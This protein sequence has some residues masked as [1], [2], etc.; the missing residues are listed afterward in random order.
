MQ[1]IDQWRALILYG[2]NVATYKIALGKVLLDLAR[3]E[4]TT[5]NMPELA[6]AFLDTYIERLAQA[7][8]PQLNVSGRKTL[9]ERVVGGVSANVLQRNRAI[10]I[11][12]RDGFNDVVPRFHT[13]PVGQLGS[14]FYHQE[15]Y[16]LILDDSLIA[17]AKSSHCAELDS[18]LDS[19]W[20]LL[21]TAFEPNYSP[22]LLGTD[23]E[24]I[25]YASAFQRL[26]VTSARPVLWGYQNGRC[27][28]C[29]ELLETDNAHV[30]H[31]IPRAYIQHDEIWNLVLAHQ[32]CNLRKSDNIPPQEY[33]D[34]LYRRNEYY[35]ASNHP[36]KDHLVVATGRTAK[37]RATYVRNVYD[38]ASLA[39][40]RKWLVAKLSVLP[41]PLSTLSL[42]E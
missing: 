33:L 17:L 39:I 20:S 18:E 12:A 2:R 23:G 41:D 24:Q 37:A 13:L 25:I 35:I 9:M 42:I 5:I 21:E 19:R 6:E 3:R 8:R 30:D 7:A 27:F 32:S 38:A 15:T 31:L 4:H 16:R 34:A 36:I 1:P 40:P 11:V 29:G 14:P 22:A 26:A 28:Y 10:E